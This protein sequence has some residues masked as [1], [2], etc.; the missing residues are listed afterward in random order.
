M[1]RAIDLIHYVVQ[2]G[3]WNDGSPAVKDEGQTL[4]EALRNLDS[5]I[6]MTRLTLT[7]A[8]KGGLNRAFELLVER[9]EDVT[10]C[11]YTSH[12]HRE[13]IILLCE[14]IKIQLEQL[15]RIASTWVSFR[16]N[17]I[18]LGGD[19]HYILIYFRV[20]IF[21]VRITTKMVLPLTK[22]NWPCPPV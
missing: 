17:D 18:I 5:L 20:S 7:L 6:E 22:S 1:R 10:D 12:E 21:N 19:F 9:T 13:N 4:S 8:D 14:R 3:I 2:D 11:P 15:V 16:N